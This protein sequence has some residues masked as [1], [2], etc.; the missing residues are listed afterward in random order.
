MSGDIMS[1]FEGFAKLGKRLLETK[2]TNPHSGNV[3]V[4]LTKSS[5]D[6]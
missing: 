1:R 4:S 2:D 3:E 5:G 6:V